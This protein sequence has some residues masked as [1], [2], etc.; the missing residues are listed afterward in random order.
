[1]YGPTYTPPDTIE[2]PLSIVNGTESA[3]AEGE[4]N[5]VTNSSINAAKKVRTTKDR[6]IL[7]SILSLFHYRHGTD[8]LKST[9]LIKKLAYEG[10]IHGPHLTETFAF[11]G[12]YKW[13]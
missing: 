12:S 7:V 8:P 2:P 5:T 4:N 6:S 3:F 10:A 13:F 9:R 11:P 1:L